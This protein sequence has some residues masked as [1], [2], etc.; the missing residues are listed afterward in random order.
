MAKGFIP[1]AKQMDFLWSEIQ[2]KEK[3]GFG[4]FLT[5]GVN[6]PEDYATLWDQTYE[7]SGGAGDTKARDYAG[8][9]YAAMADGTSNQALI[10]PNAKFTYGYLTNKGMT[11]QQAAGVTG[12]L[13]AESYEEMNPDARNT[14]AGGKGT[15]GVAQWRGSRMNDLAN[16]AGVDVND[17]A[18]LPATTPGG[19]LLTPI[20]GA[21]IMPMDPTKKPYMMGGDQTYSFD[22][23]ASQQAAQQAQTQQGGLGGLLS[24]LKDKAMAV[25]PQTGLTGLE[26]FAV[27]LDPLIMTELRGGEAIQQRGEKRVAAGN[28]NRTIEMLRARGRK[29]LADMV[30]RGMISISDAAGQMLSAKPA[31]VGGDFKDAQAFRK[32]FTSLPRIKGFAGVTEA[33]SRIVASAKDPSAAGD[34]S[35]IFNFMKVLD[36]GST[37]REGEFA[38]A[39]NAGGVDARV[40]SLFN[41]VVDGTRLDVGQR[42]DFLDRANRLYKSQEIL[43]APLYE[44]YGNIATSRGF[45]PA[46]VLPQFGYTGDMPGV[47]P[48]FAAMPPPSMPEGATADGQPLT[49]PAWLAIWNARSAEEKKKFMETGAFE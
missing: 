25:D 26:Q 1:L 39:Q 49:Q 31:V 43:V 8:S 9:V 29:D 32:E 2:G 30:E 22:P 33:Y 48:E 14:M 4:K 10:S 36:P 16:F 5:A 24:S 12:R 3:A 23:Q 20:G 41:S 42:A 34:L 18:S 21:N 13:M 6:T 7:R 38:T 11:P 15:Y 27:A 35:L 37:V 28:K 17:I 47:A 46:M 40:R 44:T 45:D 19:G